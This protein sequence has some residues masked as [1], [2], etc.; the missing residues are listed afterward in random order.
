MTLLCSLG[1]E[2]P[3]E[4][5]M[6]PHSSTLAWRIPWTEEPGRLQS[7]GS[8]RVGHDWATSLHFTS[9]WKNLTTWYLLLSGLRL[10]SFQKYPGYLKMNLCSIWG[11]CINPNLLLELWKVWKVWKVWNIF[12]FYCCLCLLHLTIIDKVVLKCSAKMVGL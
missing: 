5:A 8:Q 1:W 11:W 10:V 4:K 12:T 3:L 7:M 9:L 2:D 6:A